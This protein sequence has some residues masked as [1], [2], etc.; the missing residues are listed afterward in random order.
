MKRKNCNYKKCNSSDKHWTILDSINLEAREIYM[1]GW[2]CAIAAVVSRKSPSI[3]FFGPYNTRAFEKARERE[4]VVKIEGPMPGKS[5]GRRGE[6]Q[7]RGLKFEG[8]KR[9][10]RAL[11]IWGPGLRWPVCNKGH[12]RHIERP[13]SRRP[14]ILSLQRTYTIIKSKCDSH[15]CRHHPQSHPSVSTT[16]C[17]FC[18]FFQTQVTSAQNTQC[19]SKADLN[20]YSIFFFKL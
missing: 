8:R 14:S 2:I 10:T 19:T 13:R 18:F 11:A 16:V 4:Q 12:H 9:R 20:R 15:R 3:R 5:I 7:D 1:H 6:Q 17:L